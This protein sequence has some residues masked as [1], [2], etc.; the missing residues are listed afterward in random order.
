MD[1]KLNKDDWGKSVITSALSTTGFVVSIDDLNNTRR[2]K[3][4]LNQT[5]RRLIMTLFKNILPLT[6]NQ[7][8][9]V[10]DSRPALCVRSSFSPAYCQPLASAPPGYPPSDPVSGAWSW[11]CAHPSPDERP[12]I[13]CTER[14]QCCRKPIPR[15]NC[16]GVNQR[17][18]QYEWIVWVIV[19]KMCIIC[20]L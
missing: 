9:L 2:F 11:R 6:A 10:V 8:R 4:G 18:T 3:C 15:L 19:C 7:T 17:C 14:Y 20:N 1:G 5:R 16:N 13:S 12:R